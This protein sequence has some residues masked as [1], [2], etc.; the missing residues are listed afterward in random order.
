MFHRSLKTKRPMIWNACCIVL[1]LM[2]AMP[3]LTIHSHAG[4]S[5]SGMQALALAEHVRM[6]HAQSPS[7][8]P[9]DVVHVH[10]L[11][12]SCAETSLA[13]AV[14]SSIDAGHDQIM[15]FDHG[16]VA[17]P[18]D[19]VVLACKPCAIGLVGKIQTADDVR[20]RFCVWTC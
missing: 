13:S 7:D 14:S 18:V 6:F 8:I 5:Q 11:L 19:Y 10:W 15:I 16:L 2:C 3:R 9:P 1:L 4:L 20:V 17:D 12:G